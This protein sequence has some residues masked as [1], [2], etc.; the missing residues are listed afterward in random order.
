MSRV[1][2]LNIF[3]YAIIAAMITIEITVIADN[4]L[5]FEA[6][7][8]FSFASILSSVLIS[9]NGSLSLIFSFFGSAG[10]DL[11]PVIISFIA[12]PTLLI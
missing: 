2:R 7:T 10:F 12:F 5:V 8:G 9:A 6:K 1:F 3:G 4:N 11:K